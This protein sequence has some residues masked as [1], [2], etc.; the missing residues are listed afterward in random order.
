MSVE[1]STTAYADIETAVGEDLFDDFIESG[2]VRAFLERHLP[3]VSTGRFYSWLHEDEGRYQR[4]LKA[5]E[6]LADIRFDELAERSKAVAMLDRE[7]VPA[8]KLQ[9]EMDKWS[10]ERQNRDLFGKQTTNVNVGVV[11]TPDQWLKALKGE[12]DG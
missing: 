10:F 2:N 8:A 1:V 7:E 3:G 11:G 12:T 6:V 9:W 4:W 5:R